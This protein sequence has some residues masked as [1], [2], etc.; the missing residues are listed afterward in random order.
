MDLV[1]PF[2]ERHLGEHAAATAPVVAH[3][4]TQTVGTPVG[5]GSSSTADLHD[6]DPGA[7]DPAPAEV[8]AAATTARHGAGSSNMPSTGYEAQWG[9]LFGSSAAIGGLVLLAASRSERRPRQRS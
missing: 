2:L 3:A 1:R 7:H 8:L 5:G 9:V 4:A 6:S